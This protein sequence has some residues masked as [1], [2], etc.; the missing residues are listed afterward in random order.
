MLRFWL[1]FLVKEGVRVGL[2]MTSGLTPWN[3]I[4]FNYALCKAKNKTK[5]KYGLR[6][7]SILQKYAFFVKKYVYSILVLFRSL[8]HIPRNY[9]DLKLLSEPTAY[10]QLKN[11]KYFDFRDNISLRMSWISCSMESIFRNP[12]TFSFSKSMI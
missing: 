4:F 9:I 3:C 12:T 10:H 8:P 11:P 5:R 1:L 7:A 6:I 2:V